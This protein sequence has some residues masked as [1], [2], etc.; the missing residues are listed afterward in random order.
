MKRILSLALLMLL[1]PAAYG[2][3]TMMVTVDYTVKSPWQTPCSATLTTNC[4]QGWRITST[5]GGGRTALFD[6]PAPTANFTGVV[7]A[8][9]SGAVGTPTGT[10]VA[11][12]IGLNATGVELLSIDSASAAFGEPPGAPSITVN[13]TIVVTP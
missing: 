10:V 1:I 7:T 11:Q 12:T 9:G 3:G 13:L 8:I 6:I 5:T 4:V 2:Q